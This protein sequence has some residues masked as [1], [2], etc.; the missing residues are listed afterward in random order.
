MTLFKNR[1]WEAVIADDLVGSTLFFLSLGVG[2]LTGA[3]ALIFESQTDWFDNA[4]GGDP[5][6]TAF[7]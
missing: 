5:K 6:V 3:F 1:G 4:D 2:L 7:V